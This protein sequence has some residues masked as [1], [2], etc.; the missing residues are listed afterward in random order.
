MLIPTD[1]SS[2]PEFHAWSMALNHW[3]RQLLHCDVQLT[4]M[5]CI[6]AACLHALQ[7]DL[8]PDELRPATTAWCKVMIAALGQIDPV[9]ERVLAKGMPQ[10][11]TLEP[12]H[13]GEVGEDRAD[14]D[15]L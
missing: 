3:G 4:D 13:S 7:D 5:T 8:F 14:E 2:D 1:V 6:I 9:F 11:D 15:L 10:E 12:R